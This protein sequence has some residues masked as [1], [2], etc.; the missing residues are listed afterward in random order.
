MWI[1]LNKADP[2]TPLPFP[3]C[4]SY[5]I[6]PIL[7]LLFLHVAHLRRVI[8]CDFFNIRHRAPGVMDKY[9]HTPPTCRLA[10]RNVS[11]L[12]IH[13]K[14]SSILS[15]SS[16][17]YD[18]V[19]HK[20]TVCDVPLV[21]YKCIFGFPTTLANR[22]VGSGGLLTRPNSAPFLSV[23]SLRKWWGCGPVLEK[24]VYLR[25]GRN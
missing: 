22:P 13:S 9:R 14:P 11:V 12:P 19:K 6:K 18:S 17:S 2:Q 24:A 1:I 4:E 16:F 7:R 8:P 23:F 5:W 20:I 10:R 15:M 3:P 25:L 21:E